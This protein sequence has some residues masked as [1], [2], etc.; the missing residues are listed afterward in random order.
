MVGIDKRD[1]SAITQDCSKSVYARR[2]SDVDDIF[3]A[4]CLVS[5][6]IVTGLGKEYSSSLCTLVVASP[7]LQATARF[8]SAQS[9]NRMVVIRS[10]R[11][12]MTI[13][14]SVRGVQGPNGRQVLSNVRSGHRLDVNPSGRHA[15]LEAYLDADAG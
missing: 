15:A 10:E 11:L 12:Y 1:N 5:T 13:R 4:E 7:D 14:G 9:G 6:M 2:G 8:I 3:I